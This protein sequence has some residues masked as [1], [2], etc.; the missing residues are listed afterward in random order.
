MSALSGNGMVVVNNRSSYR[1][2]LV[3]KI[4]GSITTYLYVLNTQE[5]FLHRAFISPVK[6]CLPG[7]SEGKVF[8]ALDTQLLL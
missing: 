3:T 5:R 4:A 7:I 6:K 1:S 2:C 8:H